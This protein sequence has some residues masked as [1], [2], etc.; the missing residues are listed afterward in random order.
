LWRVHPD[1]ACYVTSR[2]TGLWSTQ[3]KLEVIVLKTVWHWGRDSSVVK[4]PLGEPD[5]N[6]LHVGPMSAWGFL[7]GGLM[8]FPICRRVLLVNPTDNH[9]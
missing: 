2:I 8:F 1:G 3:A 9:E 5:G 7:D 6:P 4:Y